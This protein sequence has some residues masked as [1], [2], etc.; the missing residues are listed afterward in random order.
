VGGTPL[1]LTAEDD[2]VYVSNSADDTVTLVDARSGQPAGTPV[3]VGKDPRG[4]SANGHV[5][6]VTSHGDDTV[7]RIEN[8]QVTNTVPVGHNPVGIAARKDA[9]WVANEGDDTVSRIDTGTGRVTS[10]KVG[11]RPYAVGFDDPY[12]WVA[13]RGSNDV[14]RL[15]PATGRRVGRPI[16]IPGEPLNMTQADG[17]LWVTAATAR[18]VTQLKP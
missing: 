5:A 7:S 6:W 9:I 17:F 10:T 15:D 13:D 1:F 18:T 12:M 3:P 8:G 16:P 4:I 2:F 14:V 11:S